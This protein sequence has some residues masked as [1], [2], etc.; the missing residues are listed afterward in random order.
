M[1]STSSAKLMFPQQMK[2]QTGRGGGREAKTEISTG[3][4][5]ILIA[6]E[7]EIFRNGL[8]QLL[9]DQEHWQVVGE[10]ANGQEVVD[11]AKDL[12]PDVI[13]LDASMPVLDGLEAVRQI[14]KS[15]TATQIVMLAEH[16]TKASFSDALSVG[17]RGYLLKSDP[18][19]DIVRAIE[20]LSRRQ[21]FLSSRVVEFILEDY[22]AQIGQTR[23]RGPSPE[24]LTPRERQ[25]LQLLAEGSTNKEVAFSLGISI[26]TASGHR[27]SLMRK[28]G[29]ESTSALVR[30]AIRNK[31]IAL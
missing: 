12:Q 28:L 3:K 21:P 19:H 31:I 11:S 10:A 16:E 1:I 7:S 18:G 23:N 8:R 13:V 9:E 27:N 17:V 30:Y 14:L 4:L 25:I 5:R 20:A 15:R 2:A 26:K 6:D 24:C 29:L 22:R